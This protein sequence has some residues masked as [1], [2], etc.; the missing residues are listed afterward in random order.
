M[1]SFKYQDVQMP[2]S[3]FL[4]EAEIYGDIL[5]ADV[6][7][8]API[9]KHHGEARLTLSMKNLMG[10]V[11]DRGIFHSDFANALPDLSFRVKSHLVVVDAIRILTSNGP[12]GGDL[13]DVQELDTV[14]ATPDV[15]AA[16]AYASTLF[17]RKPDY[18]DYVRK[19]AQRGLGTADLNSIS[20]ADV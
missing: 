2:N 4:T 17:G 12:Q 1:Q 14:I 16:D 19:A 18:L 20:I 3:V 7:I 15:V 5:N 9:A 6:L 11:V 13:S 8:N 10:V